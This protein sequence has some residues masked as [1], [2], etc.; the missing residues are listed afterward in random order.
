M[1]VGAFVETLNKV[2]TDMDWT[3]SGSYVTVAVVVGIALMLY[4]S[5]GSFTPATKR[6]AAITVQTQQHCAARHPFGVLTTSSH[7]PPRTVNPAT[8]LVIV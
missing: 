8:R 7:G 5:L 6:R 3:S 1:D 2:V 4:T